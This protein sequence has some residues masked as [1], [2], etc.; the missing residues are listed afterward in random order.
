[1]ELIEL[2]VPLTK[3]MLKCQTALLELLNKCI[4]QLKHFKVKVS[5]F[6]A[7]VQTI[8]I[9]PFSGKIK[10]NINP[11]GWDAPFGM[12]VMQHNNGPDVSPMLLKKSWLD[13]G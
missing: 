4:A 6:L 2:S 12:Y 13:R 1:M 9:V 3:A 11:V 5:I 8:A 10:T 7:L